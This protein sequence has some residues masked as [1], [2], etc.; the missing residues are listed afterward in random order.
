[1]KSTVCAVAASLLVSA[2]VAVGSAE[3]STRSA[4]AT[5]ASVYRLNPTVSCLKGRGV[6]IRVI[7]P[8]DRRLRAMRDLAQKTSRQARKGKQVV[9]LAFGRTTNDAILLVELLRIPKDVYRLERK[10]NV[11]L[12]YRP[13]ASNLRSTVLACLR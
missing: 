12:L 7:D 10:E 3:S 11:V 9:G 4:P 5:T 1:M 6:A 8:V 13:T 2:A